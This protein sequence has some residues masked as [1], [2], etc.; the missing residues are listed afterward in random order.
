[1]TWC[2]K[3]ECNDC[4]GDL[5][6]CSI[7]VSVTVKICVMSSISTYKLINDISELLGIFEL[8]V[9]R[10]FGFTKYTIDLNRWMFIY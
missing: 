6:A 2:G 5:L 8:V 4:C 1:M 7:L 9:M 10:P 3:N